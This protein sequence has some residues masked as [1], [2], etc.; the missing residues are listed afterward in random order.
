M[1]PHTYPVV[2]RLRG[3]LL[4]FWIK[5]TLSIYARDILSL[6]RLLGRTRAPVQELNWLSCADCDGGCFTGVNERMKCER[7]SAIHIN[8]RVDHRIHHRAFCVRHA[9]LQTSV[10]LYQSKCFSQFSWHK[11][12]SKKNTM[13]KMRWK[14]KANIVSSLWFIFHRCSSFLFDF[15]AYN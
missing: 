8:H 6:S 7:I 3:T 11:F 13:G 4:W 15:N 1:E 12:N 9:T 5:M 14:M 2:K 10:A